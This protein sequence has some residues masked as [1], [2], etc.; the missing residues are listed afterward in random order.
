MLKITIPE[1]EYFN[2]DT[3]EFVMM[4]KQELVQ[5]GKKSKKL[6]NHMTVI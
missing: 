6:I 4:K 3:Q 5:I 2:E 1:R